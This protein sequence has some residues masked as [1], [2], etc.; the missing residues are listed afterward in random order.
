MSTS[1][2]T[3]GYCFICETEVDAD[4]FAQAHP[5]TAQKPNVPILSWKERLGGVLTAIE[6]ILQESDIATQIEK[7]DA[8][9][10][11]ELYLV[12]A[13]LSQMKRNQRKD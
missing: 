4:H 5:V 13:R 7:L 8:Q 9:V 3:E 11:K 12:R 6:E 10:I 1:Q 2:V